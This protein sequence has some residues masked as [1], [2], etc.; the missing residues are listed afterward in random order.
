M[1]A[2]RIFTTVFILALLGVLISTQTL[3][4]IAEMQELD[5]RADILIDEGCTFLKAEAPQ[6]CP[7]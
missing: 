4:A 5:R 2:L 1:I 7:H 6:F 3:Y